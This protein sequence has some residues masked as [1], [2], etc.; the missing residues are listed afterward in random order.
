[1]ATG[2]LG[3][4]VGMIRGGMLTETA[5]VPGET[6]T[7]VDELDVTGWPVVVVCELVGVTVE[8]FELVEDAAGVA[9][10]I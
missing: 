1:M 10:L 9:E 7:V 6:T 2:S 5:P 4:E 3:V 8:D